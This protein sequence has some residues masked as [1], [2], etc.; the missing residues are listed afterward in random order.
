MTPTTTADRPDVF[1]ELAG[2]RRFTS[3]EYLRL[4]DAGILGPDDKVELLGGYI[5]LKPDHVDPP[6]A[7][8]PFPEWRWLRRFSAGEYHRMIDLGVIGED[9][10][11]ERLDGYLV[12]KM[13]QNTP[14][15]AA[16]NRLYSRVMPRLPAG[17]VVFTNCPIPLGES[18]PEP[19]GVILRGVDTDYDHRDPAPADFGI[20]IEVSDST[21]SS[22]RRAK[23]EFYAGAGLPTFWIINLVDA[24]VEVYTDPD[25]AATPPAYR[26]RTDDRRGQ[27]ALVVLDGAAVAAIPMAD[28]LP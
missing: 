11:L 9:E 26:T 16:A 7:D 15:R 10:K 4:I 12:L 2:T 25:P 14:H 22:D 23:Q 27:D 8:G 3:E 20:V 13:P 18:D 19:D 5:L 6:A 21:L 28:L 24:Q 1:P 17:W